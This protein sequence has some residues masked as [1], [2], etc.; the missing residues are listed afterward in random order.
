V[1]VWGR[2]RGRGSPVGCIEVGVLAAVPKPLAVAPLVP[3]CRLLGVRQ[4]HRRRL[5]RERSRGGEGARARPGSAM[6][7]SRMHA[8][9][10]CFWPRLLVRGAASSPLHPHMQAAAQT[11]ARARPPRTAA[12]A[13]MAHTHLYVQR[14]PQQVV[15]GLSH[16][17]GHHWRLHR[18]GQVALVVSCGWRRS[19]AF[20]AGSRLARPQPTLPRPSPCL[21]GCSR[22]R[23]ALAAHHPGS[24]PSPTPQQIQAMPLAQA[25]L[26]G[27]KNASTHNDTGTCPLAASNQTHRA[28]AHLPAPFP[29]GGGSR[30]RLTIQP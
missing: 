2:G 6:L 18:G 11:H 1:Q 3:R 8:V 14:R 23:P 29:A 7:V 12:H 17:V 16:R 24:L 5:Q 4:R 25:A 20:A 9:I 22:C 28:A 26:P 27:N 30:R 10:V 13:R 21:Q 19:T 15:V